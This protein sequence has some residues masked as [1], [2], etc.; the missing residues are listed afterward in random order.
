MATRIEIIYGAELGAIQCLPAF[1][2]R[3]RA[4]AMKTF[5]TKVRVCLL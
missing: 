2:S 5:A 3:C 4:F 1:A